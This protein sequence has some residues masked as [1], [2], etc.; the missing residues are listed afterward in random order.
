MKMA[1]WPANLESLSP[2][3]LVS[4]LNKGEQYSWKFQVSDVSAVK[5][6]LAGISPSE[7]SDPSVRHLFSDSSA[8]FPGDCKQ[9]QA[10]AKLLQELTKVGI[11]QFRLSRGIAE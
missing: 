4:A 3:A 10:Q 8:D 6:F 9:S 5:S 11:A 2:L 7:A 1:L